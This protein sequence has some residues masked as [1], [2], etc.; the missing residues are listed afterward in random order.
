M[1]F[2]VG[3]GQSVNFTDLLNRIL[4]PEKI[5]LPIITI[6]ENYTFIKY[7]TEYCLACREQAL[8][9]DPSLNADTF[10]V[11]FCI[12]TSN[13]TYAKTVELMEKNNWFGLGKDR[14]DIIM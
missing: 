3:L 14:V 8:K 4:A 13:D 2:E 5:E 6:E 9:L 12:M 1:P 11:P 7:Y 10:Y